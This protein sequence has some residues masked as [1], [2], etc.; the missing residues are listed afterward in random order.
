MLDSQKA[1]YSPECRNRELMAF[2]FIH[3]RLFKIL[4]M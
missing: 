1:I 2:A 4:R 3:F